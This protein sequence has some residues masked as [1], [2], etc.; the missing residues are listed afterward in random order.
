M[1]NILNNDKYIFII[2]LNQCMCI[3]Y[4]CIVPNKLRYYKLK[5]AMLYFEPKAS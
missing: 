3:L 4:I 1:I 5:F 2:L